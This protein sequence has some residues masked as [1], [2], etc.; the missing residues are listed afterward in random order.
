MT[1]GFRRRGAFT[2]CLILFILSLPMHLVTM[3]GKPCAGSEGTFIYV[4]PRLAAVDADVKEGV[5]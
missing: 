4:A 5:L 2:F 3:N 1:T